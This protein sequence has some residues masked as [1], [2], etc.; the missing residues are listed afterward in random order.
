MSLSTQEK[1]KTN[2]VKVPYVPDLITSDRILDDLRFEG[3]IE[4]NLSQ[5]IFLRKK[6]DD[7]KLTELESMQSSQGSIAKNIHMFLKKS[8]KQRGDEKGF[9]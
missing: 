5:L 2:R 4:T 7:G 8:S 6:F 3:K 9:C 1:L